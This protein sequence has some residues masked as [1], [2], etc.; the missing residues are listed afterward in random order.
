M[1]NLTHP[2]ACLRLAQ[3]R[4]MTSHIDSDVIAVSAD[5]VFD[6]SDYVPLYYD[7][8]HKI[9][10]DCGTIDAYRAL[11]MTGDFHWL[12]FT[13]GKRKGYHAQCEDPFEAMERAKQCWAH[14]RAVRQE[15]VSVEATARDLLWGRQS[16]D[17]TVDD[18]I[19]SPLCHM[20]IEGCRKTL[21]LSRVTRISGRLAALIMK[22][23]PQ[24]GFVIHAAMQ[25]H[26]QPAPTGSSAAMI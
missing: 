11:A 17:V 14:R 24:M 4:P 20:G 8:G 25:R 5:M 12:V 21:G 9:T 7:L 1:T 3:D 19:A 2:A 23:E 6:R 13:P 22:I 18:L 26:G 16:F 10:S 15:W